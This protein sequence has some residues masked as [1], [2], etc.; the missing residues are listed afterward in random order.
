MIP[1]IA[2][3][4]GLDTIREFGD[5][6]PILVLEAGSYRG[7]FPPLEKLGNRLVLRHY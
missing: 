4:A 1:T 5:E 6:V 2:R 7:H 3:A